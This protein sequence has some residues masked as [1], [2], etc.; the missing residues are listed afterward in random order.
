M[1]SNTDNV[2]PN[3]AIRRYMTNRF[4]TS[5]CASC[6]VC[7]MLP[8]SLN[9]VKAHL[10]LKSTIMVTYRYMN[11][12]LLCILSSKS[13]IMYYLWNGVCAHQQV[14]N[15][16]GPNKLVGLKPDCCSKRSISL[17]ASSSLMTSNQQN[18]LMVS[19][20]ALLVS[21]MLGACST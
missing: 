18:I 4:R 17:L 2:T 20:A 14:C 21:M 10:H 9:D 6:T 7:N 3:V 8:N 15:Y 12:N 5:P 13:D 16:T 19:D 1:S 11:E